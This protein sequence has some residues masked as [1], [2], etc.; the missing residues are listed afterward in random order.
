[1]VNPV[2]VSGKLDRMSRLRTAIIASIFLLLPV[3]SHAADYYVNAMGSPSAI[4][5]ATTTFTTIGPPIS[6]AAGPSQSMVPKYLFMPG[7]GPGPILLPIYVGHEAKFTKDSL[8]ASGWTSKM[9]L[10][11]NVTSL[12][13]NQIELLNVPSTALWR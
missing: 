11:A 1:M 10:S 5:T 3:M 6:F 4:L 7:P 2:S 8:E 9:G 13:L 12:N